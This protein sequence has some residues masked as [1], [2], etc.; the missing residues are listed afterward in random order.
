MY[1]IR[2][3]ERAEIKLPSPNTV[4]DGG[5]GG[6]GTPVNSSLKLASRPVEKQKNHS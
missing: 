3:V 1:K 2:T 5:S 6:V 4:K